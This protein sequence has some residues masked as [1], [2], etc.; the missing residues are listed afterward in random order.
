MM[1]FAKLK[2][3]KRA[4]KGKG[5]ARRM[6]QAGRVPAVIYGKNAETISISL[7]PGELKHLLSGPL[8]INTPLAL[9]IDDN[10]KITPVLAIVKDHQYEPVSRNL[11]HVDF[12]SIKE[13]TPLEIKVPFNTVG[14]SKGEQLGGII[15]KIFRE[16][17]VVCVASK[18]PAEITVD[19]TSLGLLD[20][21]SLRQLDLPEGV[22]INLPEDT[23]LVHLITSRVVEE[24]NTEEAEGEAGA[25]G[26][27]PAKEKEK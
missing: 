11:L 3:K 24:E 16:L 19:V 9:E 15:T 12:L 5:A 23:T 6:R 20:T 7:V 2:V 21:I 1:E 4:S 17:P 13:D 27:A 14:R 26:V 22:T 18:I 10:G 8:R 25:E